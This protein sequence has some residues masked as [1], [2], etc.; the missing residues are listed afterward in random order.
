MNPHRR[1]GLCRRRECDR[2]NGLRTS[3]VFH[4]LWGV[5]MLLPAMRSAPMRR[6]TVSLGNGPGIRI[7]DSSDN[8][9]GGIDRGRGQ[10]DHPEPG[11]A[12]R[13]MV[14][15]RSATGSRPTASSATAAR[16]SISVTTAMTYNTHRSSPGPEQPPELPDHRHHCR[17]ASS[18][19]GWAAAPP[20]RLSTSSSFAGSAAT[21]PTGGAKPRNSSARWR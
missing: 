20:T 16:P 19:D 13:S 18:R 14:R 2:G 5:A 8:T 21:T 11:R 3:R 12:L 7:I 10:P 9:I 1:H 4:R 17:T 6:G 15:T